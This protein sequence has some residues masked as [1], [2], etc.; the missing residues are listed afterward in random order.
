M[1]QRMRQY[2]K[3]SHERNEQTLATE[4]QKEH[5]DTREKF[6]SLFDRITKEQLVEYRERKHREQDAMLK[7]A[8]RQGEIEAA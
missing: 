1:K 6:I 7:K 5:D 4:K 8:I 3:K 2:S